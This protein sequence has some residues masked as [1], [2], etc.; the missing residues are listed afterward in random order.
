MLRSTAV[1]RLAVLGTLLL[2]ACQQD[3]GPTAPDAMSP[4]AAFS[5]S[6][7]PGQRGLDRAALARA[8]PGFGGIYL[9][10]DGLPTVVLRDQ[11]Q[12]PQAERALSAFLRARGLGPAQLQVARGDFDYGALDTWFERVSPEVLGIAGVATVD[13]HETRNRV[14]I[15]VTDATAGPQVRGVAARIGVP[16]EALAIVEVA[17]IVELATLQEAAATISGG[18]QI[19]F[20][21]FICTLGFN[22]LSGSQESFITNSHCTDTQGGTEGTLY[23]QPLSS[24]DP[25]VIGTEVDDPTY[26]RNNGCPRGGH[27]RFSDAARVRQEP[28]RTFTRGSIKRLA[29]MNDPGAEIVGEYTITAKF[30]QDS[31]GVGCALEGAVVD[32][33]GRTTGWTQ[34]AI[35]ASCVHVGVAGSNKVQLYQNIVQAGV[36]SGDSGSPVFATES[37]SSN[38][39]LHGILWGGGG[40]TFVY[41]PLANIEHELGALTVTGSGGP[42][43]P[44]PPPPPT[45]EIHVGDLD[46]S[47][48]VKGK[49]GKWSASVT[50]TVHDDAENDVANATVT[51]QMSGAA[52]GQVSGSTGTDGTVT[53]DSGNISGG[54]SVAFTVVSV[55]HASL[56]YVA[57]DNHDVDGDT[58]GN[59]AT[60]SN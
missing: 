1:L 37:G 17:P 44:P 19:H 24:I 31:P 52:S 33:I 35:D 57:A 6:G 39:T 15:G 22:A 7:P 55:L 12:R 51:L 14:V 13:L 50:V 41:S 42:T 32:K 10:A 45:G 5:R 43:P 28:G 11:A 18:L 2:A 27:C 21:G 46:G 36:N 40:G 54:G 8:I 56:D 60:V 59:T 3:D 58:N 34:G 26:F 53:L 30:D 4:D 38:V 48:N 16:A 49:S 29:G 23:Y 20:G 25:T 9:D 47:A